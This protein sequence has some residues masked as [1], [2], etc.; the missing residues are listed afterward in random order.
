MEDRLEYFMRLQKYVMLSL[1]I[2]V[3]GG[4]MFVAGTE[5]KSSRSLQTAAVV[6]ATN[7]NVVSTGS[8]NVIP[9]AQP[10]PAYQVT[11]GSSPINQDGITFSYVASDLGQNLS[12][13]ALWRSASPRLFSQTKT[14]GKFVQVDLTV[15][16]ASTTGTSAEISLNSFHDQDGR[17]Y[18]GSSPAV[19]PIADQSCGTQK[20]TGIDNNFVELRPDIPCVI[21]AVY[22][23]SQ[24]SKSYTLGFYFR[25]NN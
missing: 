15:V 18:S 9:D 7:S 8:V 19:F 25:P 20:Y 22:E 12:D 11:L 23:V 6:D 16:S 4:V 21:H 1:A 17:D 5:W 10:G 13:N 24:N 3:F 2:L 14:D